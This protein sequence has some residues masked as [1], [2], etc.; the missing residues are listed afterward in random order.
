MHG[1]QDIL[2]YMG[3]MRGDEANMVYFVQRI[4]GEE[5]FWANIV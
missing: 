4:L 3:K 2:L 5:A 1:M